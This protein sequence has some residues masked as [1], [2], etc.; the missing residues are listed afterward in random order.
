MG[1]GQWPGFLNTPLP[2]RDVNVDVALAR[3]APHIG[4]TLVTATNFLGE[5]NFEG[6]VQG[7]RQELHFQTEKDRIK[8]LS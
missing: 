5:G 4:D 8:S 7:R 6:R 2:P 3:I 1:L